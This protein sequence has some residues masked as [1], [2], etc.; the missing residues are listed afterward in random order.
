MTLS[1]F[2]EWPVEG[3]IFIYVLAW[4][5]TMMFFTLDMLRTIFASATGK[6]RQQYL[7][8]CTLVQRI[9]KTY[10][11]RITRYRYKL[12]VYLVCDHIAGMAATLLLLILYLL[13]KAF[14]I[15]LEDVI[16]WYAVVVM[17]TVFLPPFALSF[18]LTR[19]PDGH[20]RYVFDLGG[21]WFNERKW[22]EHKRALLREKRKGLLLTPEAFAMLNNK[23][24]PDK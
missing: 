12:S 17:A 10:I 2:E 4:I 11:P 21:K 14:G 7:Q 18:I 16:K 8:N 24:K 22:V 5:G 15:G 23:K 20:P 9:C 3:F 1:V 13:W 19:Y 6:H